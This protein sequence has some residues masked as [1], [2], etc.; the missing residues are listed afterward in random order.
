M[1]AELQQQFALAQQQKHSL[2]P[3]APIKNYQEFYQFYLSEHHNLVSR[4]L[5]VVGSSLGLFFLTKAVTKKKLRYIP[6]GLAAGYAC[7]WLGHFGFEKNKPASFKQPI[8]SFISDWRMFS[9]VLRGRLSL[10]DHQKDKMS[11][12]KSYIAHK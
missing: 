12:P 2:I 11:N 7:A 10:T 1:S 6:M 3:K 5:H 4:R 8:Y 9:D